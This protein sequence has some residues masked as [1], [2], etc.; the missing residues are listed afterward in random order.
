MSLILN[1][2]ILPLP[3][4]V[5]VLPYVIKVHNAFLMKY[6]QLISYSLTPVHKLHEQQHSSV[7]NSHRE[8][9]ICAHVLPLGQCTQYKLL[10]LYPPS[11]RSETGRYTV[12][13]FVC[14][15]V[16]VCVSVSTPVFNSVCPSHNSSAVSLPNPSPFPK[17]HLPPDPSPPPSR[18]HHLTRLPP[19]THLPP[20]TRLPPQNVSLP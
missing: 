2:N 7:G 13:I 16:C 9:R 10:L 3:A 1:Y 17:T 12:F 19:L 15:G 6:H 4:D 14:L 20:Q 18:L 8:P 5:S 11:E